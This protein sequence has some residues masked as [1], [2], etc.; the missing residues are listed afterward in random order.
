[1]WLI[2]IGLITVSFG[3]TAFYWYVDG[4]YGLHYKLDIIDTFVSL[5]FIPLLFLYF[6]ELTGDKAWS[7]FR[8][9][10]LFLP[11]V[12]YGSISAAFYLLLGE[13]RA[14]AFSQNMIETHGQIDVDSLPYNYLYRIANVYTYSLFFFIQSALVIIY[15]LRRLLLY[16]KR[17]GDFFSNVEGKDME[18]HW[19]VFFG[20]LAFLLL[21][22][23]I[24]GSGYL[25]YVEYDIWIPV[26]AVLLAAILYYTCRQVLLS[27]YTADEFNREIRVS[28]NEALQ[29]GYR[30]VNTDEAGN[31][32][33]QKLLPKFNQVIDEDKIFLQKNLRIDDVA[34]LVYTN[35]TYIS[36]IL[37]EEYD[38]NFWEFINR[39]RIGYAKQ[40]AL[41]NPTLTVE[42]LADMCGFSHG[43]TFSRAFRQCEGVTYTEW[44]KAIQ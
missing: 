3:I 39:K 7:A 31:N 9:F 25:H 13:E 2:A 38:C 5:S 28:D 35:R 36:H 14:T 23:F 42:A 33:Y 18:R 26:F 24:S 19:A 10:L 30:E 27:H 17:L 41:S 29:K 22:L 20:I 21:L 43:T 40:Q 8:L 15:S 1:M 6:R 34:R 11:T 37:K 4:N 16:R 44:H 32:K 12:V